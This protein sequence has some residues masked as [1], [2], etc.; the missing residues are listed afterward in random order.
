MA[1]LSTAKVP[2]MIESDNG[3]FVKS[4]ETMPIP[5]NTWATA[6][7]FSKIGTKIILDPTLEEEKIEDTRFT[8][9][10]NQDGKITALQK[11]LAGTLTKEELVHLLDVGI[12]NL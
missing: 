12:D 8:V 5:I 4:E 6:S 10:V 1:A 3:T 9:G 11:G 2:K 7:T